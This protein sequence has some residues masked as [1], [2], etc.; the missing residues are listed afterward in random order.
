MREP[1]ARQGPTVT[2]GISECSDYDHVNRVLTTNFLL[3]LFSPVAGCLEEGEIPE[4][5]YR[6]C[7][8][9]V[10]RS[11]SGMRRPVCATTRNGKMGHSER[12]E[13]L[14]SSGSRVVGRART[15]ERR[16]AEKDKYRGALADLK[17][18][19]SSP[20]SGACAARCLCDHGTA[21]AMREARR[22]VWGDRM[23]LRTRRDSRT[24]V[25]CRLL[26]V[27]PARV[28][29]SDASVCLHA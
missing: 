20:R 6:R 9:P 5:L 19:A 24:A 22:D 10:T 12:T 15:D 14:P 25:T 16:G 1:Q 8:D 28:V 21:A 17:S 26:T 13:A 11:A 4:R 18:C 23:S 3:C 27:M 29:G 7:G 2:N